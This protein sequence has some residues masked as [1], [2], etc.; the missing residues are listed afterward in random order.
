M[1]TIFAVLLVLALGAVLA[2]L[3]SGL[4]FMARGGDGDAHR[5]N[6]AMRMRVL[7]QG[8]ALTLF[9]LAMLTRA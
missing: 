2:S 3:F 9:V 5:S 8:A 1:N 7:L 4:F 6:K